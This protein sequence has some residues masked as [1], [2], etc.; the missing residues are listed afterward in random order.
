MSDRLRKY[1]PPFLVAACIVLLDQITKYWAVERLFAQEDITVIPGVF[2]FHFAANNGAAWSMFAGQRLVL[3][4]VTVAALALIC[5]VLAKGW[6]DTAAGRL[7]MWF[8]LGGALGN[9]LDRAFRE[10]GLVVD[11]L[12][13][14]LINF[15]IFNVADIFITVGGVL[16]AVF[17]IQLTLREYRQKRDGGDDHED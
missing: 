8:V 6:V 10:G 12:D 5:Y 4:A 17:V 7:G 14:R 1:L 2:Y 11:F 3:L 16:F 15:P 13:F 9:F